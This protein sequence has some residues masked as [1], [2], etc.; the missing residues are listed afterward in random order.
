[1]RALA[2][3]SVIR[4]RPKIYIFLFECSQK[5]WYVNLIFY[6]AKPAKKQPGTMAPKALSRKANRQFFY[7]L[8]FFLVIC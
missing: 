1:M 6:T 7:S 5:P 8:K 3:H 4:Y 2:R